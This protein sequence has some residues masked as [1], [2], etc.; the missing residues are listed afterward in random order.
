MSENYKHHNF[1]QNG[2]CKQCRPDQ[3]A[4]EGAV[5]SGLTLFAIPLSKLTNNYIESKIKIKK[6]WKKSVWFF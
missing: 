5:W 6:V 4:P 2:I 3:T 1:W